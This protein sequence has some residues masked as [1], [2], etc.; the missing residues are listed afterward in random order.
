MLSDRISPGD[1]V[2]VTDFE[3]HSNYLPWRG[4]ATESG[5]RFVSIGVDSAGNLDLE[6]LWRLKGCSVAVVAATALANTTGNMPELAEI[7]SFAD[8]TGALFV[9]DAAQASAH[10]TFDAQDIHPDMFAVSGHKAA[11]PKGIGGLFVAPELLGG[12]A[13][14]V[15]GGT[16][17]TVEFDSVQYVS[18]PARYEAGTQDAGLVLAWAASCRFLCDV[19]LPA[20]VAHESRL[21]E[22]LVSGLAELES[23]ALRSQGTVHSRSI[24]P[25]TLNRGH[26]HDFSAFLDARGI[27]IRSGNLCAQP[28]MASTSTL[29][30]NRVSFALYNTI[31]EVD[32]LLG[33][34]REYE[35]SK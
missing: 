19:G 10:C 7:R 28:Y 14:N 16:V 17:R 6:L 4:A 35:R 9:V 34:L 26:P 31:E 13:L 5:A 20:I 8:A 30:L 22:V 29:G 24:A 27:C 15:G 3:H 25:L 32:L 12:P 2:I 33:S 18:G 23:Y 11:C 21:Y 1:I